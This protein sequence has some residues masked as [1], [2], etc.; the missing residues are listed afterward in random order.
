MQPVDLRRSSVN[1]FPYISDRLRYV[2]LVISVAPFDE[3]GVV[4][5]IK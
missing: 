4:S 3:F 2:L 5:C 1:S